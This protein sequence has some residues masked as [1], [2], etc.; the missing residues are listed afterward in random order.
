MGETFAVGLSYSIFSTLVHMYSPCMC[1]KYAWSALS[2]YHIQF[3][4]LLLL[5]LLHVFASLT[6]LCDNNIVV[7]I[8]TLHT[9]LSQRLASLLQKLADFTINLLATTL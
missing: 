6:N 9:L 1:D 4:W 5:R 8:I 3:E 2:V 7:N